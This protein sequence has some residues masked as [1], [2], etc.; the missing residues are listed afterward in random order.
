MSAGNAQR[1][2]WG[3]NRGVYLALSDEQK[4]ASAASAAANDDLFPELLPQALVAALKA[5]LLQHGYMIDQEPHM[6][7]PNWWRVFR[8]DRPYSVQHPN[9]KS[10][11]RFADRLE[12]GAE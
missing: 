1:K 5:R 8:T 6:R 2:R 9:L 4:V 12:R 3:G 11:E 7:R 10:V